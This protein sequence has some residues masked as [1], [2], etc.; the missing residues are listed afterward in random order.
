MATFFQFKISGKKVIVSRIPFI[1]L[2]GVI[3]FT[4]CLIILIVLSP[5]KTKEI[6]DENH[7]KISTSIASL[8]T[9]RLGGRDQVVLLRGVDTA[10]PVLL[11]L[12]GG[13]GM[14]EMLLYRKLLA[15][16][17]KHFTLVLW[18][19][20]GAGKS[21]SKDIPTMAMC[22]DSFVSNTIELSKWL[23]QRFGKRN[24]Y[25]LGHS[26]GTILGIKAIKVYPELYAAYIGVGQVADFDEGEQLSYQF[27][28]KTAQE[29]GN[30]K[31]IKELLSIGLPPYADDPNIKKTGIERTW[32]GRFGGDFHSKTDYNFILP[33]LL[34][35]K[36]YTLIEKL[37][38]LLGVRFSLT[39]MWPK[40]NH[41]NFFTQAAELKV[42]IYFCEGRY[43]HVEPSELAMRYYDHVKAPRKRWLWFENSAH[44]PHFEEPTK[45]ISYLSDVVLKETPNP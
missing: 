6:C 29:K 31:A 45:F 20:L 10:N 36:E 5:G 38:F 33:V 32:V 41:L 22:V 16:L 13:P 14:A 4:L 17:E 11:A 24:I 23:C 2:L 43:D 8:Q 7:Q 19:Q 15:D 1:L 3:I 21:Y 35:G 34:S 30:K 39:S 37:N 27:A 40:L 25:L 42:P 44:N 12:H 26:W 18:D 28:L 9:V